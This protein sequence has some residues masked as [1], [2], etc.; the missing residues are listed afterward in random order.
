MDTGLIGILFLSVLL[1]ITLVSILNKKNNFVSKLFIITL[2]LITFL[3]LFIGYPLV[4]LGF[5]LF[6]MPDGIT[7]KRVD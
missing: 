6:L 5:I 2:I 7:Y 3:C 1:F 4:N